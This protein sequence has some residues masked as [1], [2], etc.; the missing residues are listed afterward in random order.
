MTYFFNHHKN[1][2][3]KYR[4]GETTHIK[5]KR[6]SI[7]FSSYTNQPSSS[8]QFMHVLRHGDYQGLLII[9]LVHLSQLWC[10][11]YAIYPIHG[12]KEKFSQSPSL[13]LAGSTYVSKVLHNLQII[14]INF[15]ALSKPTELYEQILS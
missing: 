1:N 6:Y 5:R 13:N 2:A 14:H 12:I 10:F 15:P 9:T 3:L 11:P 4:S 8:L 7:V